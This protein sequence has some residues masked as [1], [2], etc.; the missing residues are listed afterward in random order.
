M[1]SRWFHNNYTLQESNLKGRESK[2]FSE[3][4][5]SS[6]WGILEKSFFIVPKDNLRGQNHFFSG[7]RCSSF[8]WYDSFMRKIKICPNT[9]ALTITCTPRQTTNKSSYSFLSPYEI[10]CST[11]SDTLPY[12]V[13]F[14]VCL[15]HSWG[16]RIKKIKEVIQ[17]CM[18]DKWHLKMWPQVHLIPKPMVFQL[19]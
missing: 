12:K 15:F 17:N 13:S 11:S 18:T 14:S 9:D 4:Q 7:I 19:Q 16:N 10:F 5:P 2:T 6:T 8:R 1:P 3:S